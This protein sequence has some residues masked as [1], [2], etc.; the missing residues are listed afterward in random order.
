MTRETEYKST[1]RFLTHKNI[2]LKS[3]SDINNYQFSSIV[4]SCSTF[5]NLM[6]CN[7][8][9]FHVHHQIPDFTQT[10]VHCVG[11]GIQPTH[12]LQRNIQFSSV[13]QLYSTLCNPMNHSTPSLPVHHQMP[14]FTQTHVHRVGDGIQPCHALSSPSPP[15]LNLSQHQGLFQ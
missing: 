6:D 14:E 8:P 9:G 15:A 10:H 11:D 1:Q 3:I 4:Q 12:P 13:A 5:C 7:I 2:K